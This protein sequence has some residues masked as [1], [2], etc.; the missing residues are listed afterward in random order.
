MSELREAGN[1]WPMRVRVCPSCL[2]RMWDHD[3][4]CVVCTTCGLRYGG[5]RHPAPK[6]IEVVPAYADAADL[7]GKHRSTG[8]PR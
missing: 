1:E 3:Y 8:R 4:G 2:S 5:Q 6:W 7:K